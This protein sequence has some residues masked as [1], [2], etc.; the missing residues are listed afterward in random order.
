MGVR[1]S[2]QSNQKALLR[3]LRRGFVYC[4]EHG[5]ESTKK[6]DIMSLQ[7]KFL[8]YA[9]CALMALWAGISYADWSPPILLWEDQPGGFE[10]PPVDA[11]IAVD[12]D[13]NVHIVFTHGFVSPYF[14]I[15]P[16]LI[17]VSYTKF[18]AWGHQLVPETMLSDS[19]ASCSYPRIGLFD[20][21]SLWVVWFNASDYPGEPHGYVTRSLDLN[22]NLLSPATIWTDSMLESPLGYAFQV[23][24]DR[25]VVL[26]FSDVQPIIKTILM[27]HQR[28]DGTRILDH[29]PIFRNFV[30]GE[31]TDR[32]AG[33]VDITRDS[34]QVI[35]REAFLD[36]WQA[37]FAKRAFVFFPPVDSTNLGDHVALTPPTPGHVRD[38]GRKIE[39]L[40][41]SLFMWTEAR[42]DS[43]FM[44]GGF[45]HVV[46]R[47]DYTP[48]ARAWIGGRNYHQ[49]GIEPGGQSVSAV[50]QVS[51]DPP[52]VSLHFWRFTLPD[53]VLIEDTILARNQYGQN[54]DYS[55]GYAVSP[56][57]V[58]HLIYERSVAPQYNTRQLYYRFWRLD[59]AV[60]PS[61]QGSEHPKVTYTITPNPATGHFVIQGPLARAT[62]IRLYNIL[63]QQVGHEIHGAALHGQTLSY[64]TNDLPNGVY[65]LHIATPAGMTIQKVIVVQ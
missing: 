61:P 11:A 56:G 38:P 63:G 43:G 41:D 31:A 57:G 12:A 5:R 50:A 54:I 3:G 30:N 27:I 62:S 58:R 65:F 40:G 22:G 26:A 39:P 52:D 37:V 34:L 19:A 8:P 4:Q 1:R 20:T 33:Y 29:V 21:D 6:A 35:W 16:P 15:G 51:L 18:D 47:S 55:L 7:R 10:L 53:L 2:H 48:L 49:W 25:S 60:S 36:I 64:A 45:L 9:V 42:N 59:L 46:R 17:Q 13:E 44:D 23:L 14:P 28:P 32:V 24:P